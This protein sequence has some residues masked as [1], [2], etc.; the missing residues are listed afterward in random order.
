MSKAAFQVETAG[1]IPPG[2]SGPSVSDDRR[3]VVFVSTTVNLSFPFDSDAA[4]P[5]AS[6]GGG[7]SLSPPAH[8]PS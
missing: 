7:T 8:H 4:P 2:S 3:Y 5:C 6:G 1:G